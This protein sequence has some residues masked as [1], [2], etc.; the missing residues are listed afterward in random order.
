MLNRLCAAILPC[1]GLLPATVHA[2]NLVWLAPANQGNTCATATS[3]ATWAGWGPSLELEGPEL[4]PVG[5]RGAPRLC[6]LRFEGEEARLV[7]LVG[8]ASPEQFREAK[9]HAAMALDAHGISPCQVGRWG[10][11]GVPGLAL[12]VGNA[13]DATR[14]CQPTV[15]AVDEAAT[16]MVD[17]A[18]AAL[19]LAVSVTDAQLGWRP[20]RRFT[21]VLGSSPGSLLE[22]GRGMWSREPGP[23]SQ[24]NRDVTEQ[25]RPSFFDDPLGG[26]VLQIQL[27]D[28]QRENVE[29]M[30]DFMVHE[31]THFAQTAILNGNRGDKI[32]KW[33]FE[34]QANYQ[35]R[36]STQRPTVGVIAA[37]HDL[38]S[39]QSPR[40][41]EISVWADWDRREAVGLNEVYSRATAAVSM[42]VE[43][44]GVD[45]PRSLLYESASGGSLDQFNERLAAVSSIPFG[46]FDAALDAWLRDVPILVSE[47]EGAV[48]VEALRLSENRAEARV[49]FTSQVPCGPRP[50]AWFNLTAL[51]A[52]D[53][54]IHTINT[55]QDGI[56]TLQGTFS[57][58]GLR[59]LVSFKRFDDGCEITPLEVRPAPG[60]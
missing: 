19:E 39:G 52:P 55:L 2:E 58:A 3:V 40:L 7:V 57:D 47:A 21:V 35:A 1:L 10:Y 51:A 31:F 23:A 37:R 54:S 15:R 32:P 43:R 18:T 45:V 59:G 44:Q 49:T 29:S 5:P 42:L 36:R 50:G 25:G 11:Q 48:R 56:L 27:S 53:G 6:V 16:A 12:G 13:R 60:T 14:E 24:R 28:R 34:G 9:P 41:A 8:I 33:F 46:E 38:L 26:G 22:A 17:D 20:D 30:R 4:D